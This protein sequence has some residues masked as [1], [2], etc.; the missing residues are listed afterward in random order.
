[1]CFVD[2]QIHDFCV[3]LDGTRIMVYVYISSAWIPHMT[4]D[5]IGKYWDLEIFK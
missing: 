4:F 1:M 2:Q 3:L 5:I